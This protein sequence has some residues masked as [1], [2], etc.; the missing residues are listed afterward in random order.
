[1]GSNFSGVYFWQ[2]IGGFLGVIIYVNSFTIAFTNFLGTFF[3][4]FL[5][6]ISW[7]ICLGGFL[8]DFFITIFKGPLILFAY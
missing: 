4:R 3:E 1:M 7:M 6:Q 8:D 2:L 5:G